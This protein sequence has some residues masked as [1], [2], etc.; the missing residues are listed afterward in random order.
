M[1]IEE[2]LHIHT[3]IDAIH[4]LSN[5]INTS[6][7]YFCENDL[8]VKIKYIKNVVLKD[9]LPHVGDKYINKCYFIGLMVI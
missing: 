7:R 5:F 3:Q 6:N 9:I 8:S 1:S 2:A 4:Y